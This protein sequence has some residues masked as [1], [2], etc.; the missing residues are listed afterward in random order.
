MEAEERR[1]ED[2]EVRELERLLE[3]GEVSPVFQPIVDLRCGEVR[4]YE[5]LSRGVSPLE[6]PG[7]LFRVAEGCGLTWELEYACRLAAIRRVAA[8]PEE[9]RE[10]KRFFLN[11][12]PRIFGDPRFV[13]GFT[14]SHLKSHGLDQRLFVLEIT[15]RGTLGS[16][17]GFETLISHYINQGFQ[18]ALDDFGVGNSGL[19]MLISCVPHYLKLDMGIVQGI[20]MSPYK[21]LL[22]KSLVSFARNVGSRIIAEGIE[23]WEDLETLLLLGVDLGQGFLLGRPSRDPE[24]PCLEVS[25]RLRGMHDQ[26]GSPALEVGEPVRHLVLRS[27]TLPEGTATCEEVDRLFR[28]DPNLDHL[29]LLR[30][31]TPAGLVTRQAFYARTGGPVGY[32]LFQRKPVEAVAKRDPLMVP[33]TIPVT[34]LAKRAMERVREDLYDPV[35]VTGEGETFLGT[36]TIQQ[37][38][39]RAT[40]LEIETAQG[41]NP[42]T[43]LPGNRQIEGWIGRV[44]AREAFGVVYADLDRFKEYNDRYGFLKGDEMIRFT[45]QLLEGLRGLL[46]EGST[47]GHVG[48]DDFVL[49][50]PGRVSEEVLESLCAAFD[51]EKGRFFSDEDRH[52]GAY[53][54]TDR[55]GDR[56]CVPLVT[57]SL[58]AVGPECFGGD[59]HPVRLSELAAQGKKRAK[60]RSALRR[61][62]SY[63]LGEL[64]IPRGGAPA[65]L[66]L[67]HNEEHLHDDAFVERGAMG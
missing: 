61:R 37:L 3:A 20:G 6:S 5:I 2:G 22:V 59:P 45:G 57:L 34:A 18:L 19:L 38:I 10:G 24:D 47:L 23:T 60:T 54:A 16:Q 65:G 48:G 67:W 40:Q 63:D 36:L 30:G 32:H 29:V 21:Q 14:L 15:E 41:A 55:R 26:I 49:V 64:R 11:V 43:G 7:D 42:L 12:S 62:S 56:V 53:W 8:M 39:A 9:T 35:V 58:A 28:R 46:P 52:R 1:R 27:P 13:K 33:E 4:G 44:L 66:P 25:R 50:C 51:R 17:E 31:Q